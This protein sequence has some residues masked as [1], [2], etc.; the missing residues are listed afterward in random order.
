MANI[1]DEIRE[2][3]VRDGRY[4]N[5]FAGQKTQSTNLDQ[6]DVLGW[7]KRKQTK[8]ATQTARKRAIKEAVRYKKKGWKKVSIRAQTSY[9]DKYPYRYQIEAWGGFG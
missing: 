2:L 8:K 5:L 4:L 9:G 3:L 1:K 7:E 6:I